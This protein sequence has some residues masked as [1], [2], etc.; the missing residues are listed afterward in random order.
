MP[1]QLRLH[2]NTAPAFPDHLHPQAEMLYIFKGQ[3]N[4][5]IGGQ[6]CSL[7]PGDLCLCFPGVMHGYRTPHNAR[8]LM[9]IFSPDLFPDFTH[10]LTHSVPQHSVITASQ[11]P[12]AVSRCME[13]IRRELADAGDERV[14]RGYL[15]V[16]LA[17]LLPHMPLLSPPPQSQDMAYRILQYLSAH[18]TDPITLEDT[19]QALN[20]S[21]SHVS[22]ILS[23]RISVNFRTYINTLRTDHACTLLRSTQRSITD[24]AYACGFE[25]L[26][27]FHRAFQ[28][29]YHL[30]PSQYRAQASK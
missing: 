13:E 17:L 2:L 16:I 22:H 11:M 9:V 5:C 6:L 7:Q 27:T 29:R 23:Q 20:V 21:K 8:A 12:G 14:I 10:I 3:A 25:N 1:E 18:F 15:Q 30:S 24:I 26:R 28:D 4:L 19:A